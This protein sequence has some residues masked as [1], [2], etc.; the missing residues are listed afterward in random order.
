MRLNCYLNALVWRQPQPASFKLSTVQTR[1]PQTATR[2]R[3]LM[4]WSLVLWL[5]G[6]GCL[7]GCAGM[8]NMSADVSRDS[9]TASANMSLA[10]APHKCCQRQRND[11]A[12]NAL[13]GTP[14]TTE[15]SYGPLA[16][17]TIAA[18]RKVRATDAPGV[19]SATATTRF[20]LRF[21]ATVR[22]PPPQ[23]VRA[24]LDQSATYLLGCAFL[25]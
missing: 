4:A 1:R 10:A 8:S 17:Q 20:S 19:Q 12:S 6:I 3:R 18:S 14:N 7:A 23:L 15:A 13:T 5:G 24:R 11:V 9:A 16:G 22:D 25:I 21:A 2:F